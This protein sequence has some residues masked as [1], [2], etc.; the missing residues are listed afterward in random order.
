MKKYRSSAELREI[1]EQISN[2]IVIRTY[3]GGNSHDNARKPTK[4]QKQII[5]DVA[6]STLSS[7]NHYCRYSKNWYSAGA[8]EAIGTAEFILDTM[9][10]N[11]LKDG[12]ECN[13][14][15]TIYCPLSRAFTQWEE[16]SEV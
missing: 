12:E 9:L 16:E 14:Y 3:V 5:Y 7:L 11:T 1:A 8:Q 13:G 4:K 10:D 15:D 2:R 6:Y